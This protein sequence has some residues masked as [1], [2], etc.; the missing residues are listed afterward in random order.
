MMAAAH[1]IKHDEQQIHMTK[2]TTVDDIIYS[3]DFVCYMT[4]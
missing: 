4:T 3:I 1:D 2:T